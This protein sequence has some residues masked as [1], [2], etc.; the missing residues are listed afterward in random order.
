[1]SR[2][3]SFSVATALTLALVG[4][5][6]T[7]PAARQAS[8]VA[9]PDVQSY[10]VQGN[11]WLVHTPSSNVVVQIGE[12]GVLVV[13]SA[14]ATTADK[15]LAEINRLA[16]GK[17]IRYIVNTHA[18]ADHVGG[19]AKI[20]AA[21]RSIIAGNFVG[22]A[23]AGAANAAKVWAHENASARMRSER[24]GEPALPSIAW[25]TDTF[26]TARNDVYFNGEAVQMLHQPNAHTDGDILVYFRKSDVIAAGDVY[27]NTTFPVFNLQEGGSYNGIVAALNRII[28][29]TV[30]KDKQEGGTYVIPGHGRVADE[31]DLVE[32]RD[33]NTIIRDRVE[34]AVRKKMTLEQVKAARLVKDYEGRYGAMQG[35]WTT[36]KFVEAVYRSL[37]PAQAPARSR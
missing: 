9:A 14:A 4:V 27:I 18:H 36:D 23:G 13:D 32:Y 2:R 22:Q 7:A 17:T 16:P 29:L 12:G 10:H 8:P 3:F 19:N 28:E 24:E 33:M 20:A 21:G 26:F 25:P 37:T 15:V 34:D 31:A 35:S 30:P 11:V 1:M 6:S 5:V